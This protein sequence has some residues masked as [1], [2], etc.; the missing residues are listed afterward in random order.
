[1][2]NKIIWRLRD[3]VLCPVD[4][5]V[6]YLICFDEAEDKRGCVVI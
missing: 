2:L 5:Y 1:V 4:N 3:C 6:L